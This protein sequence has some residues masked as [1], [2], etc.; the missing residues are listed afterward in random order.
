P[1][2]RTRCGT[3]GPSPAGASSPSTRR[4]GGEAR[5][6]PCPALLCSGV[7]LGVLAFVDLLDRLVDEGGDVVGGSAGGEPLIDDDLLIHPGGAGVDEILA[8]RGIAG[9]RAAVNDIAV[10]EDLRAVADGAHGLAR[11]EEGP[12]EPF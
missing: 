10:D 1:G 5:T 8:H 3:C 7:L 2:M 12:H 9:E 11:L 6:V 4:R